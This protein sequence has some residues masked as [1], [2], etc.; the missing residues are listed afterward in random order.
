MLMVDTYKPLLQLF[1]VAMLTHCIDAGG[2]KSLVKGTCS[3]YVKC[4]PVKFGAV[5]LTQNDSNSC[6]IQPQNLLN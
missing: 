1:V 4:L 5:L 6:T 2:N 3:L